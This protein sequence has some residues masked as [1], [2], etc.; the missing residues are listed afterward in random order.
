P[1]G[2]CL[3]QT[4]NA[5]DALRLS[6]RPRLRRANRVVRASRQATRGVQIDNPVLCAIRDTFVRLLPRTLMLRMLDDTLSAA[7]LVG[8]SCP[9]PSEPLPESYTE[10]SGL[11]RHGLERYEADKSCTIRPISSRC[12]QDL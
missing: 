8:L 2:W 7:P 5:T 6:E 1:L 4:S 12:A 9:H 11:A 10:I 3:T